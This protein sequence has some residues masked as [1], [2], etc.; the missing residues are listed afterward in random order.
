M[1]AYGSSPEVERSSALHPSLYLWP[2]RMLGFRKIIPTGWEGETICKK[3]IHTVT[4]NQQEYRE[5]ENNSFSSD[6][7][8]KSAVIF[9]K[10]R[11][12]AGFFMLHLK[13]YSNFKEKD[14]IN[15]TV[16]S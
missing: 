14:N 7:P 6:H 1:R 13:V 10:I 3:P 12:P 5:S 4:H 16:S 11:I 9:L 2:Q 15:I 8:L